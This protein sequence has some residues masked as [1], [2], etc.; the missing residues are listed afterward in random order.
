VKLNEPFQPDFSTK[1]SE[2]YRKFEKD[3]VEAFQ[4]LLK[5]LPGKQTV[6]LINVRYEK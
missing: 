6:T 2:K 5:G 1:T 3:I 4:G